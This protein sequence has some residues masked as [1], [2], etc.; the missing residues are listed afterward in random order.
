MTKTSTVTVPANPDL[1]D[2][3][4]GAE[5]AYI[6]THPELKGYD[7]EPRWTDETRETVTL[8]VPSRSGAFTDTS[9]MQGVVEFEG[10][11]GFEWRYV[12]EGSGVWS[13]YVKQRAAYVFMGRVS[14][15]G[16]ATPRKLWAAST[17]EVV[18]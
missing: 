6:A 18:S 3:L 10:S 16:E 8:T 1:D 12:R 7:L 5:A 15:D 2:C 14:I 9:I 17:E 13:R 4:M 11:D